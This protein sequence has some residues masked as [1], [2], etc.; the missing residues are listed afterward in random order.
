[1]KTPLF[2]LF[3]R[4]FNNFITYFCREHPYEAIWQDLTTFAQIW[5]K[6]WLPSGAPLAPGVSRAIYISVSY[7]RKH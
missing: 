5:K 3:F 4:V 1:M 2:I 6:V 7:L